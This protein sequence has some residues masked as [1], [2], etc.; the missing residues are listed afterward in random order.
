[1]PEKLATIKV[2]NQIQF[3]PLGGGQTEVSFVAENLT[4]DEKI[5]LRAA[6]ETAGEVLTLALSKFRQKRSLNANNY[7]WALLQKLA[8][9]R[10]Q[11]KEE[12]YREFIK[13]YGIFRPV[14]VN[15]EAAETLKYIWQNNGLGWVVEETGRTDKSVDLLMY[16]GSSTYNTRQMSRLLDAIVDDCQQCGIETLPPEQIEEMKR[17]WERERKP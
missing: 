8:E 9:E 15:K 14:T 13:Q 4:Y 10:G 11:T 7:A 16:Y 2:R 12:V 3:K 1:M 6:L 5:K 17:M